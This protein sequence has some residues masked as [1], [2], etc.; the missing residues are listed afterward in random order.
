MSIFGSINWADIGKG[1]LIAF[2]TVFFLGLGQILETG[3]FPT[4]AELGGLALAGL[5]AALAYLVKNFFTNSE[6]KLAGKEPK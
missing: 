4:L 1:L 3:V 6:N 5:S 2:G